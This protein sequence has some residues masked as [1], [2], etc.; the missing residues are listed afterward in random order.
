VFATAGGRDHVADLDLLAGHH[1]PVNQQ[2][3]YRPPRRKVRLFQ[4]RVYPLAKLGHRCG[5]PRD[6]VLTFDL[7]EQLLGLL[8]QARLAL[9]QLAPPA[10][11]FAQL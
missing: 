1:H 7:R 4:A 5:Q 2:L 9:F 10:L 11:V 8:F 3:H 6:F